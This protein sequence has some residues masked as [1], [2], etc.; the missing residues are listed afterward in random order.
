MCG[1]SGIYSLHQESLKDIKNH[2]TVMNGLLFHRG[3]DASG[4]W[5]HRSESI[6]L[7]HCR[8]AIIDLSS[9]DQPMTD[10]SGNWIVF[11]GEI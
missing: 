6:G 7:A 4:I 9:G 5:T 8:L 10:P 11:S 2:L 3:P 1:I